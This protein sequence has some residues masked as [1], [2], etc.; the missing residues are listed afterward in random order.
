MFFFIDSD[1][2]LD[3]PQA[4]SISIATWSPTWA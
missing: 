2:K 4:T 1:L 3:K